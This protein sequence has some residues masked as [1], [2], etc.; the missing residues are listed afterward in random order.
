MELLSLKGKLEDGEAYS[1][2]L[3]IVDIDCMGTRWDLD[4][5]MVMTR[6]ELL[7][8]MGSRCDFQFET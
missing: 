2:S 6:T 8:S 7:S 3:A 4:Y 1:G 5:M